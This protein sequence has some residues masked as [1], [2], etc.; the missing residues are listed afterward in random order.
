M[1]EK[2]EGGKYACRRRR[3]ARV[4]HG[5]AAPAVVYSG[6]RLGHAPARACRGVP[7]DSFTG[8]RRR[9]ARARHT[10]THT[11]RIRR[12]IFVRRARVSL[13]RRAHVPSHDFS[14]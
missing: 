5:L 1:V 4:S 6:R 13:T 12:W 10:H 3:E 14:S 9:R 7:L 8:D 11:R 2:G